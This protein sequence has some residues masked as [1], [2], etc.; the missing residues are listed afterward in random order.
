MLTFPCDFT[1]KVIG[2]ND[3]NNSFVID[4]ISNI[5]SILDEIYAVYAI[6]SQDQRI[7]YI[8]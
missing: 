6:S 2:V 3:D 1:I 5:A 4:V 7:K 8:I